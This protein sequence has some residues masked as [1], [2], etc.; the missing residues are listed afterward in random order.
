MGY[1]FKIK[2]AEER[3]ETQTLCWYCVHAVPG[4]GKVTGCSWSWRGEPVKGWTAQ[5]KDVLIQRPYGINELVESYRVENC[6]QYK[7]G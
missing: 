2:T 7:P 5:R 1:R 4:K 3:P 6:P